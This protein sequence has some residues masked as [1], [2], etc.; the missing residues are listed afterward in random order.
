LN[1]TLIE[2][3]SAAQFSQRAADNKKEV[4]ATLILHSVSVND[5]TVVKA[6]ATNVAG[7]ADVSAKLQVTS[8]N[9][10]ANS[11]NI[12]ILIPL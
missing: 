1:G 12:V 2:Q 5:S 11:I 7:K 3:S 9:L 8:E 6:V 10:Q 4:E